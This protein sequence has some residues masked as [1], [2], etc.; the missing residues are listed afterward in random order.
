MSDL[1]GLLINTINNVLVKLLM[2]INTKTWQFQADETEY[3]IPTL[4][5][6]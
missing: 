1:E 4:C 5:N 6:F 2:L 3:I